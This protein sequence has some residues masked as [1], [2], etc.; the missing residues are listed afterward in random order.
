MPRYS[1]NTANVVIKHQS[2]NIE[3]PIYCR[4]A[5]E[6]NHLDKYTIIGPLCVAYNES[7]SEIFTPSPTPQKIV[8]K[9]H[10]IILCFQSNG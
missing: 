1:W 9:L 10:S 5:A 2:V 7:F 6:K 8:V 3:R 4:S